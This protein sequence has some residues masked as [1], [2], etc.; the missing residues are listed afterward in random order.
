MRSGVFCMA[1]LRYYLSFSIPESFHFEQ[2]LLIIV[3]II[4][5]AKV[6]SE[7]WFM[8]PEFARTYD[9]IAVFRFDFEMLMVVMKLILFFAFIR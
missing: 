9:I 5:F 4:T 8:C 2:L 6:R 7:K 3:I 1:F